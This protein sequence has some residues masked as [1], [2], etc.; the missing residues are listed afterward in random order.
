MEVVDCLTRSPNVEWCLGGDFNEVTGSAER[1]G[2][3]VFFNR[4]GMEDFREFIGRMEVEDIPC[5][6]GKFSWFKD[7]G[8]AMSRLD[9][10]LVSKPLIDAWGVVDQRIGK[11]DISGHAP[12]LLNSGWIDWGPKPFKF[13][14]AWFKHDAFLDFIREEWPKMEVKGR[15]DFVLFEKLKRLKASLK[16]WNREVF[17][18]IDLKVD[19]DADIINDMDVL[20]ADRFGGSIDDLV[21]TRRKAS[22]YLW[23]VPDGLNL[24]CLSEEDRKLLERDPLDDEIKEAVWDCDGSKSPGPDG[25]T[26]EFFQLCWETVMGDVFTFVKDFFLKAR[27]IKGCTSSFL[28]LIPKVQNPQSLSEYRPICLV[29]SMY[30]ILA[31]ILAIRLRNV[32]GKLVSCNQTAFVSGRS[33]EDGVLVVNEVLDLAKRSKRDCA[34]LKVDFEKSYDRVSWKFLDYVLTKMGFGTNWLRWMEGT[35]FSSVMSVLINGSTTKDFIVEKGLR[36]G[37]PLSPFL[38][39]LVMEVLTALMNKAISLGDFQAFKVNETEEVS[40]LQFADDTVDKLPFKFLGVRV[41]DSPRKYSTW[42]ELIKALKNRLAAWKGIHLNLAV[43]VCL[44]NA[45]LNALPIY[46]LSFYKAPSKVLNEITAIQRKFL[47]SG[48]DFKRSIN[49]VSWEIVCKPIDEGGLGV[50]NVEVLNVALLSKWKWRILTEE[51]DVW[52]GILETRYGNVRRKVL[53]GDISVI[54]NSDSIWWRDL[55]IS[56]NFELLL[57]QNFTGAVK[58]NIRDGQDVPFWY[59]CWADSRPLMVLFPEL[60]AMDRDDG[61]T[62]AA[63]GTLTASG[64]QWDLNFLSAGS[65]SSSAARQQLELM[66]I[67]EHVTPRRGVKDSYKWHINNDK[68]FTVKSCFIW[69]FS[70]LSG[71]SLSEE[72]IKAAAFIWNLNAPSNFLF[73]GWR[74]IHDRIATKDNLIKRGILDA[75]DSLCVFCSTSEESLSHLL[76]GCSVMFE[77]WSKVFSW[78]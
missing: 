66:E 45:V 63:A 47:W 56:D 38:F 75:N 35:V 6:G 39:V 29:G 25:F 51:N 52:K 40:M 69:F 67:I 68:V 34:V 32:V 37:G 11:R 2:V 43:R 19:K 20:L 60:F 8:K 10:F 77:I 42:R 53:I 16:V 36:Q 33:I 73:F 23:A 65:I 44:I 54:K 21:E 27:L 9:R 13:N 46:S 74:I 15:G 3:G 17:G 1:L 24:R 71:P 30:K 18:W 7:N 48:S 64:W 72:V 70:K 4:R 49:W 61:K 57:F 41:G 58:C 26:L 12:I 31:K 62:V 22:C 78:I 14:N 28:A 5:V 59:G 76:G 50:K 55:I